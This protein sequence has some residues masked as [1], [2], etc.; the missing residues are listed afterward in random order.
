M[1]FSKYPPLPEPPE[2]PEWRDTPER[3]AYFDELDR[4]TA[5]T[6]G[7]MLLILFG[8]FAVAAGAVCFRSNVG[9]DWV[10]FLCTSGAI[11]CLLFILFQFCLWLFWRI[12]LAFKYHVFPFRLRHYD[13]SGAARRILESRPALDEAEF[14]RYWP[15]EEYADAG[16]EVLRLAKKIWAVPDKMFYPNDPLMLLYIHEQLGVEDES[17]FADQFGEEWAEVELMGPDRFFAELAEAYIA[18]R[19]ANKSE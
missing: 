3:E 6:T 2:L 16:L 4:R 9:G 7:R 10:D 15:S 11:C 19:P 12:S 14:R 17:D 18:S 13:I 1:D 5:L 8:A